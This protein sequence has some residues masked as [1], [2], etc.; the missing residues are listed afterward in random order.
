MRKV[1]FMRKCKQILRHVFK[2][3]KR[4]KNTLPIQVQQE[5]FDHLDKTQAAILAKNRAQASAC[6]KELNASFEKHL[7]P[8][9]WR[10]WLNATLGLVGILILAIGIRQM[11]FEL[12]QIPTGSM[13][14]TLKEQDHLVVSKTTFGINIPRLPKHFYFDPKLAHRNGIFVFTTADM[15]IPDSNMMYFYIF[16]GKKQYVKRMMGLPGDTLY[17]YGG[18]I[19]GVDREGN[20]IT[21]Q[22]QP[23]ELD[24][25]NH[26]PFIDFDGQIKLPARP[27]PNGI[28]SPAT[29]VQTGEPLAKLFANRRGEVLAD[30]P[31]YFDMWGIKNFAMCRL[32][33]SKQATQFHTKLITRAAP[34]YLELSHH[35]SIKHINII[36]GYDGKPQPNFELT[37]SLLP[38]DQAHLNTLYKSLTT[39]RFIVASGKAHAYGTPKNYRYMAPYLPGI[40]DGTYEFQNGIAYKIYPFGVAKKLSEQHP[41]NQ[42]NF[43]R[44]LT[45][46]NLGISFAEPF[47][48]AY[49]DQRPLI[50][51]YAFFRNGDFYTMNMPI[52]KKEDPALKSFTEFEKLSRSP[53][54]IDTGAPTK[55]IIKRYGMKVPDKHYLALG[56]NY[57]MSADSRAFGFVPE[58]NLRGAPS[59]IFWPPG[60]RFGTPIQPP[61][62][63]L[64][65][66][67]LVIWALA[68]I[69]IYFGW[70]HHN[71]THK[72]PLDL[73]PR[74]EIKEEKENK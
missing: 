64:T 9:A 61:Y 72:L 58:G 27:N 68:A 16:P 34:A 49:P 66:P 42:Y 32:L 45:L 37:K 2:S 20:D 19:Y 52:I 12:M 47:R 53:P 18:R 23:A 25:V 10:H 62:P 26:V 55:E 56:D 11:W 38:L 7:A 22:L 51:R 69:G 70:R 24:Y 57:P 3:Y 6:A 63:W 41:L 48:P 31:D 15:D 71:T 14:P 1:L 8:P 50:H 33:T 44:L 59:F 65:L 67:N 43:E 46:Y 28:Y 17:F 13:R 36:K 54:F 74:P 4:K 73:G 35:P 5:L 30:A 21:S 39:A 29:I 40:P 60:P